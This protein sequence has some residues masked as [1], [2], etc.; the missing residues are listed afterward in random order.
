M[1]QNYRIIIIKSLISLVLIAV[2]GLP[3]NNFL[4]F[5]IVLFCIPIIIFSEI[6]KNNKLLYFLVVIL[7]FLALKIYL[8]NIKIQEGHNL[9]ILNENSNKFYQ[10]NLPKEVYNF[11]ND[12]FSFYFNKSKCDSKLARC[13]K[14]FDPYSIK[15][16][17]NPTDNIYATSS[18]WSFNQ[19]K[20][21]RIVNKIDF[22]NLKSARIGEVNNL[23]YNFFW[24]E[25]FDLVRMNIP[26]FVMYEIPEILINSSICWKGN[27]FWQQKDNSYSHYYNDL[28]DCKK[29]SNLDVGKLIFGASLGS[30]TSIKRLN[31]LYGEKFISEE[32]EFYKF[33]QKNEL[34]LKLKKNTNIKFYEIIDLFTKILTILLIFV[35][36]LK[37]DRRI[38]FFST[39][40]SSI[41]LVLLIYVNKD[42]LNGFDIP[43]G[44]NDGL[45]YMS[46][47]N[48]IFNNLLNLN[49]Y[50][51]FRG[52]ESVF[53]FPSSLRYFWALNKIFFGEAIYGYILIGYLYIIVLFFILNN[54]FGYIWATTLSI[55]IFITRIFEGYAL[56]LYNFLEH[57]NAGDAEP[58][59]I[60][61]LFL[62]LLIFII[63]IKGNNRKPNYFYSF[64]FGFFLFL[65]ISLRPNYLPTGVF[66]I[67]FFIFFHHFNYK[68]IKFSFFA[69]LGFAFIFSIPFHNYIYGNSYVL[70]SSGAHHNMHVPIS[71]Y[72]NAFIDIINLKWND[73]ER[74]SL[75]LNQ[76]YRWIQPNEI[77]YIVT[78]LIIFISL[79]QK[80]SFIIKTICILALSQHFV[81]LIFE[82][83]NRYAYLAWILTIIVSFNFIKNNYYKLNIFQKK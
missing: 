1:L 79:V 44:G 18:D 14:N 77:H 35:L 13:W 71:T 21:S 4:S 37:F 66:F 17:S 67:I 6:L 60:F 53:Y 54:L 10:D 22:T 5:F 55:L 3:I 12:E 76:L 63:F 38:Y 50:E 15:E 36:F 7:S 82:P 9:V 2:I 33:L 70:L 32:D 34:I 64:L 56:S 20:Y 24:A 40:Y 80:N 83:D 78:L 8:P 65:S 48:I 59:A 28:Y 26:F 41:F 62:S 19:T 57:I 75:I 47:G 31:Y 72:L 43:T 61:F 25:K 74:I 69:I 39:I 27:I 73:S 52:V 11:F 42:L 30:S 51:F 81:L 29:I 45:L 23:T 68:N 16:K 49:L 46:Y 58:L